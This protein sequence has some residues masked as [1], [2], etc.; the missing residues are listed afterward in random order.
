MKFSLNWYDLSLWQSLRWDTD[1][2]WNRFSSLRAGVRGTWSWEHY[3]YHYLWMCEHIHYCLWWIHKVV[4]SPFRCLECSVHSGCVFDSSLKCAVFVSVKYGRHS[5]VWVTYQQ[6]VLLLISSGT[7]ARGILHGNVWVSGLPRHTAQKLT[8]NPFKRTVGPWAW[9]P[10]ERSPEAQPL[11]PNPL[12][13]TY[14]FIRSSWERQTITFMVIV[15]WRPVKVPYPKP[16][17]VSLSALFYIFCFIGLFVKLCYLYR[18]Y[19]V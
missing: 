16:V 2:A 17:L 19:V 1:K 13:S 8:R 7:S 4:L 14:W 10:G 9:L 5:I 3:Y 6:E 15:S 11:D 18:R 12:V